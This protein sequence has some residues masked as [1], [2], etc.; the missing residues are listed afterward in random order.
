MDELAGKPTEYVAR[1]GVFGGSKETI[2]RINEIYYSLLN[3]TLNEGYM[4]TEES[5]YTIIT[6]QH[7]DLCNTH[8]IDSNGLVYKFF[9]DIKE[10]KVENNDSAELALYV[11]TY[12]LPEQFKLW[13]ESFIQSY[14]QDFNSYKK[15]VI[16]NSTD[17]KANKEYAKLFKEYGF[18]EFKFNNIGICGGRQFAAEH[19]STS[20]H[21]Y[22]IFFEDD[23]LFHDNPATR[24]KSGFTTFQEDLFEKSIE[25]VE[26]EGLDYLKLSFSEFYG[27]NSDNWSWYNVPQNVKSKYFDPLDENHKKTKLEYCNIHRGLPYAIGEFYYCNWPILFTQRGNKKVF[28]DVKWE[29]KYEQTWMSFVHMELIAKNEIKVGCLLASPIN[30]NRVYHYKP[31][32]RRE[33]EKYTN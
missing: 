11:L 6:Y 31:G 13:V 23:M 19:F 16:N 14:G 7:P 25:I 3:Q 20:G 5:L 12:N 33:N 9:E 24:C 2:N 27:D 10:I 30:H 8:F 28:L 29:H 17:K 1:G 26:K 32:T 4:G 21:K 18:E 15:Y 22:M